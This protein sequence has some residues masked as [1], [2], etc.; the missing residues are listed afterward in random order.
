MPRLLFVALDGWHFSNHQMAVARAS[1]EAGLVVEV[2]AGADRFSEE[3]TQAGFPFHPVSIRKS[4]RLGDAR[5]TLRELC[6][7]F[8]RL[9]PD[10]VQISSLR[11]AV[12]GGLAARRAEV[13]AMIRV[14]TGRG[15]AFTEGPALMRGGI[16][17]L[18]R[19]GRAPRNWTV[20]QNPEDRDFFLANGLADG[21][22]LS[23]VP[24]AGVDLVR[25]QSSPEPA[26]TPVVLYLG[27]ML[28]AKGV[29]ELVA[30]C[31]RIRLTLPGLRLVLAGAPDPGNPTSLSEEELRAWHKTGDAE[32]LGHLRDV[33]SLLASCHLV[34]LPTQAGE[35]M[36]RA[37]LEAA[38]CGRPVVA[39]RVP[40]CTQAVVDGETGLL[41]EPGQP[42]ALRQALWELLGDPRRRAAMGGQARAR[43]EAQFGEERVAAEFLRIQ[44][45]L[46]RAEATGP[47]P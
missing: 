8:R 34:C 22:A 5:A 47:T 25:F 9:Q 43:A 7:V 23:V 41:V 30:A 32:W 6:A 27:R 13:P 31:R 35:G 20:F 39:T 26:G 16:R 45:R 3:I 18:W 36:P 17:W 29:V 24:G 21:D 40:G 15:Y 1:R 4:R 10:L 42:A 19:I 44:R 38:A 2:V 11:A 12:L 28:R 33:P 46:L 37:L 14:L